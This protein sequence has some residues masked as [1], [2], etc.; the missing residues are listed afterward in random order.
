MKL[1]GA[2]VKKKDLTSIT[3]WH[4]Y[5]NPSSL[6]CKCQKLVE[7]GTVLFLCAISKP[8]TRAACYE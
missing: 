2:S 1:H 7:S 8:I 5:D 4:V 6:V 3:L